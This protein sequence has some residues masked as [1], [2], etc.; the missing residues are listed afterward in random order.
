MT[1]WWLQHHQQNTPILVQVDLHTVAWK[2][3]KIQNGGKVMNLTLDRIPHC[4]NS[5]NAN[6]TPIR[7]RMKEIE[8]V[9]V[10]LTFDDSA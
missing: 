6:N 1:C 8:A 7:V 3:L 5:N 9:K 10:G 2:K 4:P